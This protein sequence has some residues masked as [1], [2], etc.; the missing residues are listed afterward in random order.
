MVSVSNQILTPFFTWA[1]EEY[2][3]IEIPPSIISEEL[4]TTD[5]TGS[6]NLSF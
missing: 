2:T 5:N 1:D 4:P 6:S 3:D